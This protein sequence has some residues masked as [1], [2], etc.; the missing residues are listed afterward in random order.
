MLHILCGPTASG[1]THL[2]IEAGVWAK[3][4]GK[5]PLEIINLDSQLVYKHAQIGT[6]KPKKAEQAGIPHHLI[7][8]HELNQ[9]SSAAELV[10]KAEACFQEIRTRRHLPLF[11]G[12]SGFYLQALIF[13]VWDA[14]V[15]LSLRMELQTWSAE[16]L[17]G[18]LQAVEPTHGIHP[19]DR[20]RLQRAVEI[21]K[22]TGKTPKDFK[23]STQKK[24]TRLFVLDPPK[25]IL[26]ARIKARTREM[27]ETG[28]IEETKK[29][30]QLC[31]SSPVL[32]SVV[33][34]QVSQYLQGQ[35]PKGRLV[36]EGIEGLEYE[37]NLATNQMLKRQMAW[38]RRLA[39][40]VEESVF[41]DQPDLEHFSS[42]LLPH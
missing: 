8:T 9:Q 37:I 10:G 5:T 1:K 36:P 41:F 39:T 18:T 12:G 2:A 40:Q 11:V 19:H 30:R 29:L 3:A 14:P 27:L 16:R 28:L 33:Y 13:G 6:A 20:Y 34:L 42:K 24:P 17:F 32:G 26:R 35:K 23:I 15:N 38:F 7:D 21:Y 4:N 22:E 25:E 31:P